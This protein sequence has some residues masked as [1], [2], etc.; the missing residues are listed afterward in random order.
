MDGD[1]GKV[2]SRVLTFL[3]SLSYE[4]DIVCTRAVPLSL[5]GVGV[6]PVTHG[7]SCVSECTQNKT[8]KRSTHVLE[9]LGRAE[10]CSTTQSFFKTMTASGGFEPTLTN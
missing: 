8:L 3:E 7:F 10:Q 5:F 6:V 1:L 9:M 4:V 2:C